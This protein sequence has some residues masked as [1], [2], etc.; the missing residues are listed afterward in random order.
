MSHLQC[1]PKIRTKSNLEDETLLGL[2]DVK[3]SKDRQAGQIDETGK[4]KSLQFVHI[5]RKRGKRRE[6]KF[7][8]LE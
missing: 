8:G 2:W 3:I 6:C 4:G 7:V 1:S 5:K